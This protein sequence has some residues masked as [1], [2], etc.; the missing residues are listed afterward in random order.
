MTTAPASRRQVLP[1]LAHL[2]L[3]TN[4]SVE[5]AP[6]PVGE[7]TA[8]PP[9][10]RYDEADV[11]DSALRATLAP[12]TRGVSLYAGLQALSDWAFHLAISPWRVNAMVIDA[13]KKAQA[14]MAYSVSANPRRALD[15]PFAPTPEDRRFRDPAWSSP[16]FDMFAQSHLAME[17]WWREAAKPLRGMR[18]HHVKRIDFMVKQALNAVAPVNF[19]WSNPLV[20][21]AMVRTGGRNF[22]TGAAILGDDMS[23]LGSGRK[24]A[25]LAVHRVGETLAITPGQVVFRNALMELILYRPTTSQVRREPIL[26]VPAWIMKYYILD[27]RPENSLVK[28]LVDQGFTVFCVSWKNPEA[29]MSN[30]AFEDYRTKGV[31]QA[32]QEVSA[33]APGEKIHLAGYCLGGT[34]AATAAAAM[35]RDGDH[36]LA[37]LTLLAAQTD[38]TE[39]GELMMFIGES[40]IAAL[41]D[42]MA[43]QGYL[44]AR[45]MSGA[46][47][48]LRANE[49]V[50]ARLVER[51]LLGQRRSA[52]DLEFWLADPTRMP[53][54]MH[55]EYLRWLFLEN[56]LANGALKADGQ[57]LH[58]KDINVPVFAVGA[59][60][61]HIAPWRSVHKIGLFAGADT[62]FVLTG[63]GH[64]AGIVS[65][66]GKVGAHYRK[67]VIA[68]STEY[69]D[70]DE[71]R[72]Q[73]PQMGGS[74]WPSW[75]DW[76]RQH[77]SMDMVAARTPTHFADL[78]P[79]PGQ[80]VL[81]A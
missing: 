58:L 77:S 49:M 41:E 59:E 11:R 78:S 55:S 52:T 60:R 13:A 12:I 65:P 31:M 53:A 27:L 35:A 39:A 73:C 74:W 3:A 32:L 75:A 67:H 1:N 30:F 44:D 81:E 28:Y 63:G 56:R 20:W 18:E 40:Q 29:S 16:P 43:H 21:E 68:S 42:I 36:R 54:R 38:F 10:S 24:L 51:Y 34:V 9:Q 47:Y 48:V 37:S 33:H 46:F 50:W 2:Q 79:A 62:T 5:A 15:P 4:R 14:A 19:P 69:E 17:S 80:Y 76:I 25:D 72:C 45:Q 7:Q 66:P 70:P 6:P 26:L 64:N 71:W 22:T 8:P 61:D 23:R 57:S